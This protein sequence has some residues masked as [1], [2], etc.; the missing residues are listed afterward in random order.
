LLKYTDKMLIQIEQNT[1]TSQD[2][3][4]KL[5]YI[6]SDLD[7]IKSQNRR[8]SRDLSVLIGKMD[9]LQRRQKND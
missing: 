8:A 2:N 6:E 4:I 1:E 7:D 3:K 5:E 9:I